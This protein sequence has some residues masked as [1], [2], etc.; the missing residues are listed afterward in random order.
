[1]SQQVRIWRVA[2]NG[3]LLD[4]SAGRLD[5]E[6][7]LEDWI[8]ADVRLVDSQLLIMGRQVATDYGGYI[9]LLAVDRSGDLVLLELKR[10]KT[11]R[12]VVAQALDYASWASG[13]SRDRV[14]D[15]ADDHLGGPAY[16]EAAFR[17]K[18]GSDL[19]EIINSTHRIVV[20]ASEVDASSER[21]IQYLSRN[22]GVNINAVTFQYFRDGDGDELIT[23]VFLIEPEEIEQQVRNKGGSRRQP[24]LTGEELLQL[25]I[26]R[27]IGHLYSEA[28]QILR[29][30]FDGVRN[31]RS[32]LGF[33]GEFKE[34]PSVMLSLIP[35]DGKC[36]Q[37][38]RFQLYA[39]RLAHRFSITEEQLVGILPREIHPWKYYPAASSDWAGFEGCFMDG[40]DA[41]RLA[42]FFKDQGH[43]A[44]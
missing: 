43:H 7:R 6:E 11:S 14:V 12:E 34:S 21:I 28:L 2:A 8:N 15:I 30:Y 5:L 19:P 16:F 38:L 23:R 29:P 26:D 17:T 24:N 13:L 4:I 9:D 32:S 41:R 27:N 1:M 31:T 33:V 22:H 35:G 25:A 37:G 44:R 10:G 3:S 36:G 39:S 20:V 42:S 40:A 18:F